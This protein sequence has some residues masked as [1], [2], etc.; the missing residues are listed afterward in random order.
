[1]LKNYQNSDGSKH[2]SVQG[3]EE[4][5]MVVALLILQTLLR[6]WLHHCCPYSR[7]GK[8][9]ETY[10]LSQPSQNRTLANSVTVFQTN[11]RKLNFLPEMFSISKV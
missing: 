4:E 5:E 10:R 8:Y 1:M 3:G 9:S 7:T 11:D 2:T 6:S